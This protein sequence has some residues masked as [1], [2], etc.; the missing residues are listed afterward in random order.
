MGYEIRPSYQGAYLLADIVG[1]IV[2]LLVLI[3]AFLIVTA[4]VFATKTF[5][6]YSNHTSLWIA[7]AFCLV[8]CITGS[9]L[10]TLT[11][12]IG[13]GGIAIIGI[14]VLLFTCLAVDI[15]NRDTLQPEKPGL[16]DQVLHTSWWQSEDT[17]L[18]KEVEKL[19]A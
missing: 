11:Q 2:L 6:R 4:I 15:K 13:M 17:P 16:V 5:A 3:G 12:N 8:L 7:G 19:A 1:Q 9:L 18:E 10:F 14:A